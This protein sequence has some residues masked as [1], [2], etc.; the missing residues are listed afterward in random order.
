MLTISEVARK[1]SLSNRQVHEMVLYGYLNAADIKRHSGGGTILLF[2]EQDIDKL[3]IHS[4]LQEINNRKKYDHFRSASSDFRRM[5]RMLNYYDRFVA[6]V[7]DHP[8]QHFLMV[9]FYLFHLNHYAKKYQEQSAELY[10]LKNQV[11][12]RLYNQYTDLI[13]AIYLLG[14]DRK[15]I[16]L[17]DDCKDSAR[18]AG[19]SYVDYLKKGYYCP[20]CTIGSV[21]KEYYSLVE[22]R[23]SLDDYRFTFHLPRASAIRWMKDL[24]SLP[25]SIRETGRYQDSMYLYGRAI[26]RIE[27]R[28]L[29]LPVILEKLHQ[30]LASSTSTAEGHDFLS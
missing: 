23:I 14:P 19:M 9:C 16:W 26:S 8:Q 20:K 18:A 12:K 29:P 27:E 21:D 6:S 15:Q 25:Q 2:S 3:D 24:D 11:I 1:Y 22:F 4:I 13:Q 30:F 28:I 10:R 7:Q 5:T 17:C